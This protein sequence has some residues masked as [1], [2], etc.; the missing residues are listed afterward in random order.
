MNSNRIE[1]YLKIR[2]LLD[3]EGIG[4]IK[5]LRLAETFGSISD[6]YNSNYDQLKSIDQLNH[7]LATKVSNT[8]K[9]FSESKYKYEAELETLINLGGQAITYWDDDYP[10]PLKNIFY[11][12]IILYVLGNYKFE[13]EQ[14]ISI[15]G[16]RKNTDYGKLVTNRFSSELAKQNITIISG[17]ARGIDSVAHKAAIKASGRTIAVIGSGLD[18]IYPP[19]NKMLFNEIIENGAIISEFPLGT[20]PDAQNFPK[21]NRI[22]AGLSL[23]TLVIETRENGGAMQTA[24]FAIDQ[25]K[26]VFAIPG[27]ITS[28]QSNGTNI[29]IQRNGAK[30]VFEPDDILNELKLKLKPIVGNNIPKP[31]L[32]LSLFEEKTYEALEVF[33][34]QIDK[35]ALDSALS[36]SDTLVNLLTLEF[37]GVVQQLPGKL[38][39]KI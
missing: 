14:S 2:S 37:Q 39:K 18:V 24:K 25:N 22:I 30:L 15:V 33:P 10:Q 19:E 6:V 20:K 31:K 8:I 11:P 34:K 4:I 35:I 7:D 27:N 9:D 13:D 1:N 23:G 28:E 17:M 38:F 36:I 5:L 21:R 16:T 12:P 26:E 32:N 29:L 3:T